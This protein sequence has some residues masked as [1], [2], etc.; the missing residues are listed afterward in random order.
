MATF[1]PKISSRIPSEKWFQKQNYE[2]LAKIAELLYRTHKIK[3]EDN[4]WSEMTED[5]VSERCGE[6]DIKEG[7]NMWHSINR[8]RNANGPPSWEEG[9]DEEV[10]DD[11]DDEEDD[12]DDEEE[13]GD[14]EDDEED[15]DDD[16]DDEEE[17]GDDEEEHGDEEDEEEYGDE[18]NSEF[19]KTLLE[20]WRSAGMRATEIH[21]YEDN[22]CDI[23]MKS[24]FTGA[25]VSARV[26]HSFLLALNAE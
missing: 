21:R 14:D 23:S 9:H 13:H 2:T 12:E 16:E 8:L 26:P 3:L 25:T 24:P 17:H 4:G 20:T 18:N 19:S 11:E 22:S 7:T 15:E 10:E 5:L 1:N 6:W